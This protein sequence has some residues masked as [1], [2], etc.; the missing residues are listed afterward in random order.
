MVIN[1]DE[2]NNFSGDYEEINFTDPIELPLC[3]LI[4]LGKMNRIEKISYSLYAKKLLE[5]EKMYYEI[6]G[7]KILSKKPEGDK[8]IAMQ[9]IQI[10]A[11]DSENWYLFLNQYTRIRFSI[12]PENGIIFLPDFFILCVKSIDKEFESDY[13]YLTEKKEVFIV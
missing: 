6:F 3:R 12:M 2:I 5:S 9:K 4:V 10:L 13:D 1:L 7:N 8:A 11:E